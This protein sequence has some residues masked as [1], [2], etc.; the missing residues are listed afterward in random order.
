MSKI[1]EIIRREMQKSGLT[2]YRLCKMVE[3]RVPRRTVYDFLSGRTDT[4]TEVAWTL[5]QALGLQ[6]RHSTKRGKRPRKEAKS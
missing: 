4:T 5:M 6:I 1:R 2:T 3:G